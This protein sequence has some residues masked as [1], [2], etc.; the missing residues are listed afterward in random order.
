MPL[1]QRN[2]L[3]LPPHRR[4]GLG[5]AGWGSE[6][7]VRTLWGLRRR[8]GGR[9]VPAA[10]RWCAG[11][12][13]FRAPGSFE[14]RG[15]PRARVP[16]PPYLAAYPQL[17]GDFCRPQDCGRGR[18]IPAFGGAGAA[19]CAGTR[20]RPPHPVPPALPRLLPG[21]DLQAPPPSGASRPRGPGPRHELFL[22]PSP[23]RGQ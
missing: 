9:C 4:A 13:V 7:E 17:P 10:L 6:L 5:V 22:L 14:V 12:G 18:G 16:P 21:A 2:S 20:R 23:R 3:A 1:T 8:G 15:G 11:G 19:G